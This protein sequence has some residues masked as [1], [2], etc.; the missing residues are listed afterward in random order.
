MQPYLNTM[1]F[2]ER[3]L[4]GRTGWTLTRD[5]IV[6]MND[7][8]R[9]AGAEFVVMFLPFKSQVYWPL[10]ERSLSPE[11][12]QRA[13][14]FYLAGNGRPIDIDVMRRNRLVQNLMLR[15]LCDQAGIPFFDTTPVLEARIDS[16]ENVYFPDESHLNETGQALVADALAGFLEAR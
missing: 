8:S 7:V 10:L 9:A 16:G 12:V 6:K 2:S 14:A 5:A 13:L 3:E 15:G 11:D 4:R 1:N